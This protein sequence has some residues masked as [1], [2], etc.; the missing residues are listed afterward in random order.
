MYFYELS[1]CALSKM[2]LESH[3]TAGVNLEASFVRLL[4]CTESLLAS[5]NLNY[6]EF[7]AYYQKLQELLHNLTNSRLRPAAEFLRIYK[8]R[9]VIGSYIKLMT[10]F[11]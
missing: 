3:M 6:Y 9:V 10:K 7:L 11:I 5:E 2:R 8:T 1:V 4:Q